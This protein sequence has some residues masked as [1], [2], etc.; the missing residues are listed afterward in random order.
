MIRW[1]LSITRIVRR[2]LLVLATAS[3]PS[4]ASDLRYIDSDLL[5]LAKRWD[6]HPGDS[7]EVKSGHMGSVKRYSVGQGSIMDAYAF[8]MTVKDVGSSLMNQTW[9]VTKFVSPKLPRPRP[10]DNAILLRSMLLKKGRNLDVT[11]DKFGYPLAIQNRPALQDELDDNLGE[12]AVTLGEKRVQALM[13]YSKALPDDQ[14]AEMVLPEASFIGH[15]Y[16]TPDLEYFFMTTALA[17]PYGGEPIVIATEVSR[18]LKT[19][20]SLAFRTVPRVTDA[21]AEAKK[22][23]LDLGANK[24]PESVVGANYRA[25]RQFGYDLPDRLPMHFKMTIKSDRSTTEATYF[26]EAMWELGLVRKCKTPS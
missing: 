24:G 11:T 5:K 7:F 13:N 20:S 10:D 4:V 25:I 23:N 22:R 14:W 2:V 26:N 1:C 21:L 8:C 12:L 3:S 16:S 15:V 6:V 18:T 17:D 19:L 9:T